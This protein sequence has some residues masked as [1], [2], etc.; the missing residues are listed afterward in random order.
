MN[1]VNRLTKYHGG[2]GLSSFFW[3]L[4]ENFFEPCKSKQDKE[5]SS[6]LLH[7]RQPELPTLPEQA[8]FT[9]LRHS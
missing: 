2:S 3:G 8:L 5:F 4:H 7:L 1:Q 6:R 9:S